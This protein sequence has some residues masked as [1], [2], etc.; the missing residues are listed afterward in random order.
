[1][2]HPMRLIPCLWMLLTLGFPAHA[3]SPARQASQFASG[4]GNILYLALGVGLPLV[5]DGHD[6]RNHALRAL[7]GLGTSVLLSEGLKALVRE[8]RPDS[9]SHDSFPSGHA[10]AAFAVATA[11]S[12]FHPRQA[13]LWFLGATLIAASRVRLRRHTVGD[14]AAGAALGYGVTRLELSAPRGLLLVPLIDPRHGGM[15]GLQMSHGQ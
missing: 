6:G 12:A 9:D 1:M 2:S 13:P 8:K 5:T 10:T 4:S 3:D 11:E 14:V 7:D 15:V